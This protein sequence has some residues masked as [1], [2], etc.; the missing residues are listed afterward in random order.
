MA[1]KKTDGKTLLYKGKPLIRN[2]NTIYYGNTEDK[3]VLKL[4]I[5]ENRPV[6]ETED[7]ATKVE[8]NLISLENGEKVIKKGEK[9]G[10]FDAL[11]IGSIWLERT[12]SERKKA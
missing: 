3:L 2:G 12:L 4:N 6:S 11:D 5:L 7:V 1:E 9:G 8:V 10:V